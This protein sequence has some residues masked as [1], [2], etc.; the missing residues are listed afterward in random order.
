MVF[1]FIYFIV[2]GLGAYK[3]AKYLEYG[4]RPS[5]WSHTK[6]WLNTSGFP[7]VI[8]ILGWVLMLFIVATPI[9]TSVLVSFTNYG[10]LRSAYGRTVDWVGLKNWGY[11]WEF[12][13]NKMFLSLGRVLTELLFEQLLQ[14]SYLLVLVL[15]LLF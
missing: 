9:I 12:R 10:Y 5:K 15:L 7:W 8:S 13:E 2:S 11:W 14:L 3:V 4:S 6:R 1:V